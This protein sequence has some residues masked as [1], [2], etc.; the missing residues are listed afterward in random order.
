MRY[1]LVLPIR[2]ILTVTGAHILIAAHTAAAA[3][4]AQQ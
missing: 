1:G 2:L 4:A 3:K